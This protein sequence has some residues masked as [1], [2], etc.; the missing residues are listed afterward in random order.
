[1]CGIIAVVR[2]RADRTPP[3]PEQRPLARRRRRRRARRRRAAHAGGHRRGRRRAGG[4]RR[5]PAGRPRR[6]GA[7]R[8]PRPRRRARRRRRRARR[9]TSA[10]SRPPST[11]ARPTS[12]PSRSRTRTPRCCGSRTPPGPSSATGCAPPASSASSPAPAPASPPSRRTRRSRWRCRPLDRLEVRGRDSAGLHVL[13]R[14]HGLDLVGR[15]RA[16]PCS[17]TGSPIR[18]SATAPCGSPTATS[19]FVYKAAAEIGELGDNT[20]VLRA[21]IAADEPAAPGA[22]GARC[23]GGRRRPHPLGQRRHHQPGQRPPAQQRGGGRVANGPAPYVIGA[24][25]GDVDNH[26]DLKA[27]HG[28]RVAAEITTDA[29]VIPTLVGRRLADG[30]R[31]RRVVP[32]DG[33]RLRGLGGHRRP[34]R[35]RSRPGAARPA[36]IGPGALRRAGRGLLHRRLRALR[37]RRGDVALRAHGR[38]DAGQPRQPD[39]QPG[40]GAR[41]RRR[42]SPASSPASSASPTTAR[43]CR[44]A[45]G[46]VVTAQIT[47]RDIDRGEHAHFLLKEIGEA[48]ASFRKT[49]RG[50]LV[51]DV[52]E[53][54][55]RGA[56][57]GVRARLADG[58]IRQVIAIG[59][60]TAAVAAQS[61]AAFLTE[62][63]R[64][65]AVRVDALP[66]TELSGFACGPT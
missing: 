46:D 24:L 49:L 1:M 41:A 66:A 29:K 28:L 9:R 19:C 53:L 21:A 18:C 59:Q 44:S 32:L 35:R 58:S 10:T 3:T 62:L 43:R 34:R 12:T 4:G 60:G 65:D 26:A 40:P 56:A 30:D 55:R 23:R 50:K 2:R 45:T 63:R 64:R 36:G 47:T 16:A 52:V 38:R 33:R 39:R 20:A 25:N 54:G 17:T 6:A 42:R 27:A 31:P 51:D 7:A 15:R 22:A 13:V 11:P 8:R 57:A 37:P 48:P 61:L 14:G 5:P